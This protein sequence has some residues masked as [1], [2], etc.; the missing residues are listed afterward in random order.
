MQETLDHA[1]TILDAGRSVDYYN[2][3]EHAADIVLSA[4][5]RGFS[6]R[7]IALLSA[8][9][10]RAG[11]DR[12]SLS[13]YAALLDAL[14]RRLVDRAAT[15]LALADEVE[16]RMPRG[17]AVSAERRD[18]RGTVVLSLP[19]P[20]EWQPVDVAA[21]FHRVFGRALVVEPVAPA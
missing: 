16:R 15:V 8:L 14:D 10:T 1:A 9:I 17:E 3:W 2:R 13:P 6:H 4:D 20:H 12:V 21:R 7:S 18:R 5:L 11:R 19:V